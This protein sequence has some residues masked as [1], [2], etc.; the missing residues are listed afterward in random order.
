MNDYIGKYVKVFESGNRGSLSFSNCGNDWGISCGSYQCTL[1]YGICIDFLKKYFPS[2]S[3]N[4]YYNSKKPFIKT[5]KYPGKDYCSS[6]EEVKS[7]WVLCY[8]K[9]GKDKFFEY[10][11]DFIRTNYYEKIIKKLENKFNPDTHSRM[12][13]ECIWS[14]AV[15]KG[16]N[17]C[18]NAFIDACKDINP[19]NM[20]SDEL[21]D[22]LY[23]KRFSI[24]KF[25][26]YKK[27]LKPTT[28]EREA[29]RKICDMKPL[30]D[31]ISQNSDEIHNEEIWYV[32]QS[33][34]FKVK[35]NAKN[36]LDNIK[37]SGFKDSY[38]A[39]SNTDKLYKIRVGT[40][41][42]INNAKNLVS[43]LKSKGFDA[44]IVTYK[45]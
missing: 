44:I 6:P 17:G 40:F 4:L 36:I 1:A 25:N 34:A 29:L 31:K 26:R 33:G 15:H 14:W 24:N 9:V 41:S 21:I 28:S 20:S 12:A 27:G 5:P 43:S 19:Q 18:Y 8:N 2:E 42:N 11:H 35:A 32:V 7:V 3:K 16:V 38:I 23:D 37:R 13:Q 22:I 39:Y 45:K 10:E 30:S